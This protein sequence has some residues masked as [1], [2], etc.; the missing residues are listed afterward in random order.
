MSSP[1]L[2]IDAAAPKT[3]DR[4]GVSGIG[5]LLRR[6]YY[7]YLGAVFTPPTEEEKAEWQ[8]NTY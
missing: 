5:R 2:N 6:F 7:W 1:T 4:A 3:S 8:Q